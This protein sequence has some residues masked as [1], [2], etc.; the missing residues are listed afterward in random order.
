MSG[1]PVIGPL[2][3]GL[4]GARPLRVRGVLNATNNFVLTRMGA[5]SDYTAALA[6][7]QRRGLAEPD[8]SADVSGL[9]TASK[10]M[11]LSA[12]VFGERLALA[13]IDLRGIESLD[14]GEVRAARDAGGALREVAE[15]DPERGIARVGPAALAADDPLAAVDGVENAVFCE[16]EPL[17]R[18]IIR[19][20]GAGPQL[21]GQGV[22]SDL[23]RVAGSRA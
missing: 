18:V 16:V 14:A 8:P 7:A 13:R 20:P 4:A 6:E 12:L 5:G 1:T 11:V 3:D 15:L 17:G 19:G 22:L 2:T 21:A 23:I 10:L 9:D